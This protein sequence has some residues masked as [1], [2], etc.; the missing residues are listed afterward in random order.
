VA[1]PPE[2]DQGGAGNTVG[3]YK[4]QYREAAVGEEMVERSYYDG[5]YPKYEKA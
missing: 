3:D 2:Y 1:A 4:M 5:P